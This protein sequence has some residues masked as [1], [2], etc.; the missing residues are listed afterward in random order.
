MIDKSRKP[1]LKM[2]SREAKTFLLK[3][4]SYVNIQLPRYFNFS[5]VI[6]KADDLLNSNSLIDL[7]TSKT[8]LSQTPDVN[9]TLLMNKDGLKGNDLLLV[10][11]QRKLVHD[12]LIGSLSVVLYTTQDRLSPAFATS[13]LTRNYFWRILIQR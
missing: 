9:Y 11:D 10:Y 8:A 3:P 2:S 5:S 6:K 13:I 12:A 1:I 4:S 7:S